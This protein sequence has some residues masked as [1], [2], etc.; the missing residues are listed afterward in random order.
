MRVLKLPLVEK[1]SE[2]GHLQQE[3]QTGSQIVTPTEGGH[4]WK[5]FQPWYW[6]SSTERRMTPH[7]P[8]P[9]PPSTTCP[10]NNEIIRVRDK[11]LRVDWAEFRFVCHQ[12]NVRK[13]ANIIYR[14]S[15]LLTRRRLFS[16]KEKETPKSRAATQQRCIFPMPVLCSKSLY[17]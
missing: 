16:Q 8:H 11:I 6:P 15:A 5:L 17:L 14:C 1:A 9:I 2:D 13:F 3:S 10:K 12:K 4:P 7:P